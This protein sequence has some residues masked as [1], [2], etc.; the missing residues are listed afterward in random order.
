MAASR[1]WAL[2]RKFQGGLALAAVG[3]SHGR[4]DGSIGVRAAELIRGRP[5]LI[6]CGGGFC[7][8]RTVTSPIGRPES[9]TF[10]AD[11]SEKARNETMTGTDPLFEP[12]RID[13]GKHGW[14]HGGPVVG[15]LLQPLP[16]G[17]GRDPTDCW[18]WS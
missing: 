3:T 13:S 1:A 12:V 16:G 17:S 6:P 2:M 10:V 8:S 15:R 9:V 11:S 7:F 18:W 4:R 14:H 5:P